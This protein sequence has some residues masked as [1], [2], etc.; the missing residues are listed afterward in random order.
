M[1]RH[2]ALH[3]ADLATRLA[4]HLASCL[5]LALCAALLTGTLAGPLR[6]LDVQK[7]SQQRG[8]VDQMSLAT[9]MVMADLDPQTNAALALR[10]ADTFDRL[11]EGAADPGW[12]TFGPAVR[13]ISSGDFHAI[14]VRQFLQDSAGLTGGLDRALAAALRE[15]ARPTA[16]VIAHFR[17]LAMLSQSMGRDLCLLSLDVNTAEATGSLAAARVMFETALGDLETGNDAAGIKAPTGARLEEALRRLRAAWDGLAPRLDA[18][19]PSV[20][21]EEVVR[22]SG[23]IGQVY[24]AVE[25]T[26]ALYIASTARGL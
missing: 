6:A 15:D 19:D 2:A 9:C 8:L 17:R 21:A 18:V 14:A 23:I 16:L 12:R 3:L 22:V 25:D 13:Q 26:L 5:R 10:A 4:T 7:I 1:N 20:A 11:Q 24:S